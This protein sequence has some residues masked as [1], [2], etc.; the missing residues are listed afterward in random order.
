[1]KILTVIPARGGSK[2]VPGKNIRPVHGK[3]LLAWTIEC[4]LATKG[5]DRI[6]L[7][8]DDEAIL[9]VG[10]AYPGIAIS[11]RPEE[12][13]RDQTPT[14]PVVAQVLAE[15]EA[16]GHGPFDAILLLQATAPLREP[17]HVEQAITSLR[18]GVNTVISVAE[19][20]DL[21]PARMY[22]MGEGDE[23]LSLMPE[24]EVARRQDIPPVY[25]RNGSIYFVRRSAFDASGSLMA[26]PSIGYVMDDRYLLNIDEPRD[27]L[28]AEVLM[29]ELERERRQGRVRA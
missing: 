1:M 15:E 12:L 17:W 18:E 7:S 29:A 25:Y 27:M 6:V 20:R 26:K 3:P 11:R 9:D 16:N 5:L 2:G 23:L 4:A 8:S 13:S 22:S 10:R 21:H 14:A 19:M 24:L 28:V